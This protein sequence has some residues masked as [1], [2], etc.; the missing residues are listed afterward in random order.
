[1]LKICTNTECKN[2][3]GKGDVDFDNCLDRNCG[4]FIG[5]EEIHLTAVMQM[6]Q[7]S[8]NPEIYE[9]FTDFYNYLIDIRKLKLNKIK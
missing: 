4:K 8:S 7:Q 3:V 2:L 9:K 1:M 5:M 6:A